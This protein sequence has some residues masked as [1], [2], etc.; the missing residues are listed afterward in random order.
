MA[1]IIP[2]GYGVIAGRGRE[3]AVKALA[4]ADAAG[5][6]QTLVRTTPDGYLAPIAVI[7]AFDAANAES[8]PET[9]EKKSGASEVKTEAELAAE[10]EAANA[11]APA[12]SDGTEQ[13]SGVEETQAEEEVV[14]PKGNDSTETWLEFAATRPGFTEADRELSYADIKA[15]FGPQK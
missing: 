4:A 15:K 14:Y 3:N 1:N 9:V 8:T 6:D 10:Q 12:T 13:Q 5:V 7:E 2:E 11:A